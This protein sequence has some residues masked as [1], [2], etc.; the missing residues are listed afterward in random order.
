[1]GDILVYNKELNNDAIVW[2]E[3]NVSDNL[4]VVGTEN[5]AA[6]M[7]NAITL[8]KSVDGRFK[9]GA[10]DITPFTYS[11][12]VFQCKSKNVAKKWVPA[13]ISN[14]IHCQK[15]R[16]EKKSEIYTVTDGEKAL[17]AACLKSLSRC[18][19]VRCTKHFEANCK[20]FSI[21]MGI[22]ENMK[23]SVFDVVFGEHGFVK[24]EN[25]QV[26]TL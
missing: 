18:S 7:S 5:I 16:L 1:M 22:K 23:D 14:E 6:E 25:K 2:H 15:M 13:W 26:L 11:S 17:I 3:S 19:L 8:P 24:A 10:Y 9:F 12:V 20:D 21:D 4:W